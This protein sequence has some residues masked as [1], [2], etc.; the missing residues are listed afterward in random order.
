MLMCQHVKDTHV[1]EFRILEQLQ[2]LQSDDNIHAAKQNSIGSGTEFIPGILPFTLR[3]NLRLF[4]NLSG[5]NLNGFTTSLLVKSTDGLDKIVPD[6]IMN[7]RPPR[8]M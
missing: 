5:V 1:R 2:L 6:N 7:L 3:A 4:T 8:L